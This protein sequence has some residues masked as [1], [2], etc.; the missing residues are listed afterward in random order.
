MADPIPPVTA[1]NPYGIPP[2]LNG[3][4]SGMSGLSS[5]LNAASGGSANYARPNA[6]ASFSPGQPNNLLLQILQ[7]RQALTQGLGQPYQ[8]GV[9]MPRVSLLQG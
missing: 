6:P 4:M 1:A 2:S 8:A 9:G 5:T 3:L 7:M